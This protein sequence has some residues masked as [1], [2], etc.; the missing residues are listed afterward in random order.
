M[1][2]IARVIT[3]G[4]LALALAGCASSHPKVPSYNDR[5]LRPINQDLVAWLHRMNAAPVKPSSVMPAANVVAAGPPKPTPA[6]TSLVTGIGSAGNSLRTS[7]TSLPT[8][9]AAPPG[10]AVR[11]DQTPPPAKAAASLH[12]GAVYR[13]SA[14]IPAGALA[15]PGASS[16]WRVPAGTSFCQALWAFAARANWSVVWEAAGDGP[17]LPEL[18][19]TGDFNNA[20]RGLMRAA[21]PAG[22]PFPLHVE[23]WTR[24][25]VMRVTNTA[26][27]HPNKD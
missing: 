5:D 17:R 9:A 16:A 3:G 23:Q 19:I 26:T 24:D 25:Q 12:P 1:Q 14:P 2:H 6:S 4:M 13:C 15:P 22:K 21:K 8:P 10:G 27:Q 7:S 18:A 11:P 20:L